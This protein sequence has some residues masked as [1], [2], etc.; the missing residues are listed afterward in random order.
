LKPNNLYLILT[1]TQI[2][3]SWNKQRFQVEQYT[4][5]EASKGENHTYLRSL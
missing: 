1:L 3:Q 5:I 2:N 4:H